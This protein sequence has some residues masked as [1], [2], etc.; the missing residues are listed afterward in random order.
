MSIDILQILNN[1]L[2]GKK[3]KLF[4]FDSLF[5]SPSLKKDSMLNYFLN[6]NEGN[7]C[8]KDSP[9]HSIKSVDEIIVEISSV[10]G[11]HC[12][13]E[14]DHIFMDFFYY[15]NDSDNK[16]TKYESSIT[17]NVDEKFELIN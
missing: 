1:E 3:I 10:G 15:D 6:E 2:V 17:I 5:E 11:G 16:K 12:D 8:L 14:G 7:K 13:Y 9:F 4:K